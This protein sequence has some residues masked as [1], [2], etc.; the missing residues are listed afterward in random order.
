M[1]LNSIRTG[2]VV[3]VVLALWHA[4]WS[5]L[6]ASGIA[7]V[8]IDFVLRVHFLKIAVAVSPFNVATAALLVCVT[9]VVGFVIGIVFAFVWNA[10]HPR[11]AA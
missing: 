3:G 6:V 8:L 10:L 11:A 1:H 9:F 5:V 2:L 4:G 7:Q